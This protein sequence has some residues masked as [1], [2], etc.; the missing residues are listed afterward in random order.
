MPL[1]S[2]GRQTGRT[3]R[4]GLMKLVTIIIKHEIMINTDGTW[5]SMKESGSHVQFAALVKMGI[6]HVSVPYVVH[7]Q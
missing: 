2:Y 1:V 3:V 6:L 4:S 7:H 5:R